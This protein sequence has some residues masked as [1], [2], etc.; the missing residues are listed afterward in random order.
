MKVAVVIIEDTHTDTQV[1]L[2]A[3]TGVAVDR[4]KA[5]CLECAGKYSQDI[6]FLDIEGWEY[7]AT[8]EDSF[9]V[10]VEEIELKL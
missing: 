2:F 5:Y 10:R 8:L 6:E 4:A 7:C 3:D 1:K 9:T